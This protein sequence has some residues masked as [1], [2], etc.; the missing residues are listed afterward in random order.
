VYL[1]L[2]GTALN[3][4]GVVAIDLRAP[5]ARRIDVVMCTIDLTRVPQVFI[6]AKSRGPSPGASAEP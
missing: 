3:A 1:A 4:A 5:F 2:A 6:L